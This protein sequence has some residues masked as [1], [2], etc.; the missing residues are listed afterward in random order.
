MIFS[1]TDRVQIEQDNLCP[2]L[3]LCRDGH[4]DT[5]GKNLANADEDAFVLHR[6]AAATVHGED[7][8]RLNPWTPEI[9]G[10]HK[11]PAMVYMH[12][13]G[14]SGGRGHDLLSYDGENLA[15]NHD[16]VVMTHNHRLNVYGCLNLQQLGGEEFASSANVGLLDLVAVLAWVRENI[17]T[18]GA[19][20][21]AQRSSVNLVAAEKS[22]RLWRCRQLKAYFSA[23]LCRADLS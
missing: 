2:S 22:L 16:V 18:S 21:A 5:D 4:F 10:S 8:L 13:G 15:R 11:R 6:G 1:R 23:Q 12:G 7:C 9:N 3:T 14:V 20:Q 19:T 17:A